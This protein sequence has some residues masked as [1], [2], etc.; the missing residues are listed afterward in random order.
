VRERRIHALRC[1]RVAQI[2]RGA[3]VP[4]W[5]GTVQIRGADAPRSVVQGTEMLV[6]EAALVEE[7][8]L[9]EV[10]DITSKSS[11]WNLMAV[12]HKKW[13][14]G[15]DFGIVRGCDGTCYS[16]LIFLFSVISFFRVSLLNS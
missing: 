10:Q 13:R 8:V 7:A 5:A 1:A 16:A 14:L 12:T 4:R 6:L 15:H 2:L 3:D 11:R 9:G